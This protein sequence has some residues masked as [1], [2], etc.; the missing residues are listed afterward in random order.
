M[1]V[2]FYSEQCQYCAKL[3]EYI[4]SH[5]IKKLFKMINV[6]TATRIPPNVTIVPTI[7]D[8]TIEAPLEGKHALEYL[9]NQKYDFIFHLIGDGPYK[10]DLT[11]KINSN[12]SEIKNKIK[13]YGELEPVDIQNLYMSLPN[14]I[15]IQTSITETFGKTP[16]EAASSGIILFIK[17]SEITNDIYIDRK[18]AFLFDT[19]DEFIDRFKIFL[20][21]PNKQK[22]IFDT[23][24]NAKKYDQK[25]IFSEW[26]NFLFNNE[27]NNILTKTNKIFH[28]KLFESFSKV[29]QC[30]GDIFSE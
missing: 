20:E 26:I 29:L 15:F 18:N 10:N 16:M 30:S 12:Y 28:H 24:N 17:R 9:F 13:F 21:I 14:R 2:L 25:I 8:T 22:I 1:I 5:N 3:L 19:P 7:I 23:I 11:K 4:T 27:E 6:D